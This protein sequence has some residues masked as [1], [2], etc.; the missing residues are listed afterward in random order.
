MA[1]RKAPSTAFKKGQSGNPGGRPKI[2]A[3]I[4][5]L[6]RLR[7][8]DAVAALVAALKN[9]NERVSAATI[10]LAYGYGRPQQ[11][12][13]VRKIKSIDDLDEEELSILAATPLDSDKRATK[14]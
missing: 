14:H 7:T 3:H 6:A 11:T 2:V 12:I 9:P 4:K 10:L 5:D 1:T 13:N 8:D